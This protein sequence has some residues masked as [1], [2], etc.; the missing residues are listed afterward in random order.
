[1]LGLRPLSLDAVV[2]RTV[3]FVEAVVDEDIVALNVERG[4]C[5]GLDRAGSRIWK[6]L[7]TPIPID[8]LC[9]TLLAEYEVQPEVCKR[10]VLAL[11]EDLRAE[12]MI[13]TLD[14]K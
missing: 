12:G 6:L 14:E 4:T 9:A 5:Y 11:L 3:G 8:D 13:T 1:V 10:E 7:G 2:T